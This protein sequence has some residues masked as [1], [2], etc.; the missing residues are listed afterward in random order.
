MDHLPTPIDGEHPPVKMYVETNSI[1]KPEDFFKLPAQ[2]GHEDTLELVESGLRPDMEARI[3]NAFLQS[4]LFFAL[5]AQ[6]L[7]QDIEAEK[8]R[9]REGEIRTDGIL[10]SIIET[11]LREEQRT[12]DLIATSRDVHFRWSQ[13]D[14]DQSFHEVSRDQKN[15][16]LRA[17]MALEQA[18]RFITKHCSY[19]HIADDS[20]PTVQK[21]SSAS[22]KEVNEPR[23]D[24]LLVL[25]IAILGETLQQVRPKAVSLIPG[26]L[27]FFR[28][29]SYKETSWGYNPF[30]RKRM[31]KSGYCPLEIRRMESS[32][33]SVSNIYY[34]CFIDKH[35]R[36]THSA[37]CTVQ[38]CKGKDKRL[39]PLH[40]KASCQQEDSTTYC[41][42]AHIQDRETTLERIV[43]EGMIPLAEVAAG[44]PVLKG[45]PKENLPKFGVMSH[46]WE[47][48]IVHCKRDSSGEDDRNMLTCQL[49]TL[50][51]TFNNL[52]ASSRNGTPP[53]N[54]PFYVDVLCMPKQTA[55][56]AAAI[57]QLKFIYH[58]ASTVLVWDRNLLQRPKNGDI[59]ETCM[60]IHT[61]DWITRLWTFQEIV[62]A[63]N[64]AIHIAFDKE[65]T[66]SVTEIQE[67][68][69][70]AKNNLSDKY[71]YIRKAGHPFSKAIRNLRK[72]PDHRVERAWEAVQ[73]RKIRNAVDETIVLAS[74]LGMDV[75]RIQRINPSPTDGRN[76]AHERMA[77]FLHMLDATPG[78]G[79]PSGIIFLPGSKLSIEGFEWAPS[80]WLT[81]HLHPHRL[82]DPVGQAATLMRDGAL[83]RFPGILLH[84][85]KKGVEGSTF[86]F[87]VH[88]SMHKWFKVKVDVEPE[89]WTQFWQDASCPSSPDPAII[90]CNGDARDKWEVGVLVR[91]KGF[92]KKGE[93][94]L[95]EI[96]SRVW[97][98]L[99][100]NP[101]VINGCISNMQKHSDHV[102]FGER[103]DAQQ[104]WCVG[105]RPAGSLCDSGTAK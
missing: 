50:Q 60:R 22:D 16:W 23:A 25:S 88:E 67:R 49:E 19:K 24:E 92:L 54:I 42:L 93:I 59:F 81:K 15:R 20:R 36:Q 1:W 37:E 47:E 48:A 57:N 78:L 8:F 14:N 13:D 6:V 17:S 55:T 45:Y 82:F 100:T 32:I 96:L 44:R 85:P 27:Q 61:G 73:Y 91:S 97:I 101:T 72:K 29:H 2:Y 33:P 77:E 98:R 58:K 71:H 68:R 28:D 89:K 7:N 66:I 94:R 75:A 26:P 52:H 11:A 41:R 83:V 102:M 80:T 51:T 103:L 87:P 10:L 70:E 53:A 9:Y 76:V 79:I 90:M 105:G 3:V 18:R 64:G 12:T 39:D 31:E 99:E 46:S 104:E 38:A 95:V 34:I 63:Q 69:D 86:W 65:Q 56:R 5:L 74:V 21:P 35:G 84:C 30:C 43:R 4:W 62:L 40:M